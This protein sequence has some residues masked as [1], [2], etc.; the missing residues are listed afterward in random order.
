[1]LTSFGTDI[2]NGVYHTYEVIVK[3]SQNL[4]HSIWIQA[5][6]VQ[7]AGTDL[8]GPPGKTKITQQLNICSCISKV[9]KVIYSTTAGMNDDLSPQL[10]QVLFI[11]SLMD[12]L[13]FSTYCS[14]EYIAHV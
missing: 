13:T 8:Q 5:K 4:L 1:M 2:N 7:R 12:H 14:L 9:K 6:E 11:C 10:L 3:Q